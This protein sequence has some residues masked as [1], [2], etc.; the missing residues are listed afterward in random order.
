MVTVYGSKIILIGGEGDIPRVREIVASLNDDKHVVNLAGKTN[1][2][3]LLALLEQVDLVISNDSGPLHLAV[4]MGTPTI[5]FF[6]PESPF[7]LDHQRVT[8]LYSIKATTVALASMSIMRK[9][10][11]VTI[12]SV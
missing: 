1:I 9:T 2:T 7:N 3:Q 6:G 8:I 5:S 10:A 4:M 12:I 11:G